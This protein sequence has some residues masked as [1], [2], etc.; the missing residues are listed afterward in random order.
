MVLLAGLSL[1]SPAEEIAWRKMPV[2][3]A[4]A[5]ARGITPGGEGGQWPRGPVSVSPSDPDFLLLPVDVGGVYRSLDGGRHWNLAMAGW[6]SHVMWYGDAEAWGTPRRTR[7]S[8]D[9][10]ATWEFA[11]DAAGRECLWHG[12]DISASDGKDAKILFASDWRSTDQGLTWSPMTGCEG[13]LGVKGDGLLLGR[14]DRTLVESTDAG[15]TWRN[16]IE[17]PGGF[18]DVAQDPQ[19]GR[20]YFASEGRLKSLEKGVWATPETPHDQ[21][22]GTSVATV[23]VDE[24]RPEIVYVGGPKNIYASSAT[25]CRSTDAGATWTNLTTA[26]GPREVAWIRIHPLTREVWLNG[27]C[28]G[29]WTLAPPP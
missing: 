21:Y 26:N 19:R 1:V 4:E 3:S 22:G 13:V 29:N 2:L 25:A 8:R 16:V 9:G 7:I 17:V 28:F 5:A 18:T 15:A 6:N 24:R 10:G 14:M 11:H 12:A 23:A 20:L 27:Q